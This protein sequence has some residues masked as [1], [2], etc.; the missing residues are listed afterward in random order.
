[1]SYADYEKVFRPVFSG[2]IS[3]KLSSIACGK[4]DDQG[5][6]KKRVDSRQDKPIF[7]P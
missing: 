7:S 6:P 4:S 3:D 2:G 5:P 1:V